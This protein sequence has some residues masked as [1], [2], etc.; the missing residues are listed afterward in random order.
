MVVRAKYENGVFK[1]L[2]QVHLKEGTVLE[3][4]VP[5]REAKRLSIKS[6]AFTG[7]WKDRKDIPDGLSYVDR[8]RDS[9]RS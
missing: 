7:M 1:P 5:S 4:F 8:L 9:P 6:F 2:D 3:I